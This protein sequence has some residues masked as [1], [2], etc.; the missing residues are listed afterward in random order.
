LIG[1]IV[2]DQSDE[3]WFA[4]LTSE[5]LAELAVKDSDHYVRVEVSPNV[6][7]RASVSK[8]VYKRNDGT[9]EGIARLKDLQEKIRKKI[10]REPSE[11]DEEE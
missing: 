6:T 4:G 10:N 7:G 9:N 2:S 8:Y 5:E 3:E 11:V 1:V